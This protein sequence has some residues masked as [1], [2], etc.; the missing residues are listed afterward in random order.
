MTAP[1]LQEARQPD[2]ASLE[3]ALATAGEYAQAA[4]AHVGRL[5]VLG[6]NRIGRHG[7]RRQH[8]CR[9]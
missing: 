1:E 9:C 7:R 5:T 2:S 4:R 8:L 6:E 3:P